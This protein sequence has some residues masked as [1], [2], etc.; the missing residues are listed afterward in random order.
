[1]ILTLYWSD[2]PD[3]C[4]SISVGQ[5]QMLNMNICWGRLRTDLSMCRCFPVASRRSWFYSTL[6]DYFKKYL[7][8][9]ANLRNI[10]FPHTVD[11]KLFGG[12]YFETALFLPLFYLKFTLPDK[13]PMKLKLNVL[14][15]DCQTAEDP[16][17]AADPQSAAVPQTPA[18]APNTWRH[19]KHLE[20]P[21]A[22]ADPQTPPGHHRGRYW[23][24]GIK[25]SDILINCHEH[26]VSWFLVSVHSAT[27]NIDAVNDISVI[28]G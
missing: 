1:M 27:Y 2:F 11:L 19:P 15:S 3:E 14:P 25:T 12:L 5:L 20:M 17:T 10:L 23:Y 8:A 24:R 9:A 6:A 4:C 22:T 18:N 28:G 7:N 26:F 16:Q 13:K 21:Q